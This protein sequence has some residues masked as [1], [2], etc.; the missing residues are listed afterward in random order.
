MAMPMI[1][2]TAPGKPR[3]LRGLL[4][5]TSFSGGLLLLASCSASPQTSVTRPVSDL[6]DLSGLEVA[7]TDLFIAV[8]DAKDEPDEVDRPR[9]S[10]LMSP[11]D[12]RGVLWRPM[13]MDWPTRPSN[14][15]ESVA[16]I[17]AGDRYLLCESGN[18]DPLRSPR[19][20]RALLSGN[21]IEI[22]A[23]VDWPVPISNVEATA[24][25]SVQDQLYFLYAERADNQPST[26]LNWAPFNPGTMHFGAFQSVT[27]DSLDPEK[28]A[29]GVVGLDVDPGGRIYTVASFDPE[30]VGLPGDPDFGPFRSS[31]WRVGQIRPA[32]G[33]ATIELDPQPTRVATIDGF[34]CESVTLGSESPQPTVYI[35]FDDENYA[36]TLRPLLPADGGQGAN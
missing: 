24:V 2:S 20:F 21:E 6:P 5:R 12:P 22:E 13:R 31:V 32:Q 7:G 18:D 28:M 9:V 36:G 30:A 10:L 34:K 1:C 14:D 26:Q 11:Q 23:E 15:L 27:L 35:G 19:I 4:S 8:H 33:A 3:S 17:G 16:R 29:R 25:A